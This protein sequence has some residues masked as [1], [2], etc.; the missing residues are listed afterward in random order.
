MSQLGLF[1]P[2][3][4][5]CMYDAIWL[6]LPPVFKEVLPEHVLGGVF[7]VQHLGKEQCHFLSCQT[8]FHLLTCTYRNTS[9]SLTIFF[10]QWFCLW[11]IHAWGPH[12][13]QM[14]HAKNKKSEEFNLSMGPTVHFYTFVGSESEHNLTC[15]NTCLS[16]FKVPSD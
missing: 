16:S 5:E 15:Y 7:M 11:F 6:Y 2:Y 9:T 12:S 13:P 14:L 1:F 3:K 8:Q 10:Q 4:T